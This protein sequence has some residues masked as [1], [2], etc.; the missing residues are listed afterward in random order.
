M[1]SWKS[2]L[3][4]SQKTKSWAYSKVNTLEVCWDFVDDALSKSHKLK[5][6]SLKWLLQCNI[7]HRID[8]WNW[9]EKWLS[10]LP[11]HSRE[12][13]WFGNFLFWLLCSERGH[14]FVH[15]AGHDNSFA[16]LSFSN[17]EITKKERCAA[18]MN[19]SQEQKGSKIYIVVTPGREAWES[20]NCHKISS[21]CPFLPKSLR[22]IILPGFTIKM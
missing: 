16:T 14:V 22:F 11:S 8:F 12:L 18:N 19:F 10:F 15:L 13:F 6:G 1:I 17:F 4:Y 7:W 3:L 2:S 20:H 5:K 9:I 21:L